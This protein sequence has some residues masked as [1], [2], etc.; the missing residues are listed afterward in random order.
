MQIMSVEPR[1]A[2]IISHHKMLGTKIPIKIQVMGFKSTNIIL[3]I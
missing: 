3:S 1:P 2:E